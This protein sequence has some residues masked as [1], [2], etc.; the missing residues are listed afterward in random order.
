MPR[1]DHFRKVAQQREN[2]T[3]KPVTVTP[4]AEPQPETPSLFEQVGNAMQTFI[5]FCGPQASSSDEDEL[6]TSNIISTQATKSPT[7]SQMG[8]AI[9]TQTAARLNPAN[10]SALS[11]NETTQR[12][13]IEQDCLME[14]KRI[15]ALFC[16]TSEKHALF[17]QE[18]AGRNTLFAQQLLSMHQSTA[19]TI[20]AEE[21][22]ASTMLSDDEAATRPQK[23][24]LFQ[25][26]PAKQ[27]WT[28]WFTRGPR[29]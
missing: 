4:E 20:A 16:V 17:Q 27:S 15:D 26:A 25:P 18:N 2:T 29:R 11:E 10:A 8:E 7:P 9:S 21:A 1:R 13:T 23:N 6:K 24:K 14:L 12:Q 19:K 22:E 3:W 5:D 28:E